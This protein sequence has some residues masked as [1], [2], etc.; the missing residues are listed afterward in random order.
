VTTR[1]RAADDFATIR[2]RMKELRQVTRP[3]AADDFTVIRAR[4]VELR[5][6]REQPLADQ[7][8]H[9]RVAPRPYHRATTGDAAYQSNRFLPRSVVRASVR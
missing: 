6:E 2:G 5:R 8:G 7:R 3:R 9:S 1:P 4:M